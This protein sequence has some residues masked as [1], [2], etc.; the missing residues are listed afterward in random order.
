MTSLQAQVESSIDRA[1][2]EGDGARSKRELDPERWALLLRFPNCQLLGAGARRGGEAESV[3][4]SLSPCLPG[5]H[6]LRRAQRAPAPPRA[7]CVMPSYPNPP[8]PHFFRGELQWRSLPSSCSLSALS[9]W[10][11]GSCPVLR[12]CRA[13]ALVPES[14]TPRSE[15]QSAKRRRAC[16]S[17]SA[18]G[19]GGWSATLVWLPQTQRCTHRSA[20]KSGQSLSAVQAMSSSTFREQL[21]PWVHV[22][23]PPSP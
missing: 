23:L 9:S 2:S 11:A 18:W 6:S 3:W 19:V 8:V 21:A 17:N 20:L 10:V 22:P 16:G 1:V 15:Q 13:S 14:R 4:G 12:H 7:A 5:W